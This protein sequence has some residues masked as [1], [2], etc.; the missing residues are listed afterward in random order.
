MTL[1]AVAFAYLG[2]AEFCLGALLLV[3]PIRNA[4]K[5]WQPKILLLPPMVAVTIPVLLTLAGWFLVTGKWRDFTRELGTARTT[6]LARFGDGRIP[7]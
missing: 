1:L 2:L 3:V 7:K 5:P 4:A 6:L